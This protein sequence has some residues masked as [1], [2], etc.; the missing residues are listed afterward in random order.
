MKILVCIS[1]V[2]D[3]TSK[4]NFIDENRAFD[5][6]GV[7]FV[8]NPNDE[9]GLTRAIWLQQK[10]GATVTVATVGDA[11]CEAILRKCLAIG[12]DNAVRIDTEAKDGYYVAAQLAAHAEKEAYDLVI[13]GRE[14][15]DYNGGMVGGL[16][17]T[18]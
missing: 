5:T 6:Q 10:E 11:S 14:S 7:T 13:T 3:T 8:I 12:A 17:A 2:P 1:N 15:I 4:I 16:L 9:F 18:F